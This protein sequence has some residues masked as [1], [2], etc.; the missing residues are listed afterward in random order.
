MFSKLTW[1]KDGYEMSASNR[2]TTQYDLNTGVARLIIN[3]TVLNDAGLYSVVAENKAGS[4]R[5]NA[6]LE[7]EREAGIDN[8]PIASG[9]FAIYKPNE[10][11]Q[12]PVAATPSREQVLQTPHYEQ[13]GYLTSEY[14][15]E[16]AYP[17]RVIIPLKDL[18]VNEG[19]TATLMAKIVGTPAPRVLILFFIFKI[20]YLFSI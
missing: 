11:Q 17:P 7:V 16:P 18:N 5:T 2:F 12:P 8:K 4:D 14:E 20:I 1:L 3:G 15:E 19:Q 6:R 13:P 9:S 10:L